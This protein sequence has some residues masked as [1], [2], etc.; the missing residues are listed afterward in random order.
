V[1]HAILFYDGECGLCHGAVRFFV[2]RDKSG[3]RF[4]PLY[5]TTFM[6]TIPPDLA[7]RLPDSLVV[8]TTDGRVLTRSDAMFYL[9]GRLALPYRLLARIGAVLPRSILNALYDAVAR[10]RRRVFSK[11][12][13]PCPLLPPHLTE[14]FDP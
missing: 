7:T 14:R 12:E 6:R 10:V 9:M 2:L 13:S 11:P 4:A 8:R 5:G 1:D 3:I